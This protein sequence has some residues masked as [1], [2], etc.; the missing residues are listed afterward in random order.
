MML[1]QTDRV[2]PP[3]TTSANGWLIKVCSVSAAYPV[4]ALGAFMDVSIIVEN[5]RMEFLPPN[6]SSYKQCM[7]VPAKKQKYNLC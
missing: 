5:K 1:R 7:C 3:C 4:M 2:S 6:T